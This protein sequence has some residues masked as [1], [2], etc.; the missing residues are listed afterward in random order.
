MDS[1]V[2]E[3]STEPKHN[4]VPDFFKYIP[5]LLSAVSGYSMYECELNQ[6]HFKD[7]FLFE[8][9]SNNNPFHGS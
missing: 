2:T 8:V 1:S 4:T 7:T 3:M 9:C 6:I 5:I